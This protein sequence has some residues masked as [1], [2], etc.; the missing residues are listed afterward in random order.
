MTPCTCN[1]ASCLALRLQPRSG[2]ALASASD[3]HLVVVESLPYILGWTF[4]IGVASG[5]FVHAITWR[6]RK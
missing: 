5:L 2:E 6:P 1:C 3:E 4:V